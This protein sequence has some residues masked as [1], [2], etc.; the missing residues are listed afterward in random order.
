M[1][2]TITGGITFGSIGGVSIIAPPSTPTAGWYGGGNQLSGVPTPSTVYSSQVSRITFATDT[3]TA[4]DRGPLSATMYRNSAVGNNTYGWYLGGQAQPASTDMSL[5]TRITYATDTATSTNR[6]PL[7]SARY[8]LS[9]AGNDN[10]GWN[11]PGVANPSGS[12]SIVD[13]ITYANDTAT[14][15][16]RGKLVTAK[17]SYSATGNANYGWFVGGYAF[18]GSITSTIDRIDYANDT[19]TATARGLLSSNR[20]NMGAST[21]TNYG[22]FAGG[23]YYPG[24]TPYAKSIVDRIDYAN[25]TATAL[26]RGPLNVVRNYARGSGNSN[27]GWFA[28]GEGYVSSVSRIDYANDTATAVA[29]GPL[30]RSVQMG[31]SSSGIQ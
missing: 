23:Y 13:R 20:T 31:T 26:A 15:S 29:K 18:T 6:G 24:P 2:I 11:G 25:D 1:S 5:V 17:Y 12:S 28:M 9:S 10:Y 7:N 8:F 4:T 3:A 14:A 22:Y 19:A 27:Y 30:N 21:A 16:S